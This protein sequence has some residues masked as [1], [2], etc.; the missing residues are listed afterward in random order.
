MSPTSTEPIETPT[1]KGE[2]LPCDAAT[3]ENTNFRLISNFVKFDSNPFYVPKESP[4]KLL[5]LRLVF[6]RLREQSKCSASEPGEEKLPFAAFQ[7]AFER[8]YFVLDDI[9][10]LDPELYDAKG[11]GCVAWEEFYYMFTKHHIRI[12]SSLVERIHLT[13]DNPE[14]S[15]VSQMISVVVLLTIILS[16]LC[17]I[18]STVPEFQDK[19]D[20]GSEPL[21]RPVFEKIDRI[22]VLLFVIEYFTRLATSWACRSEL[23][24][25]SQLLDIVTGYE[26]IRQPSSLE[27]LV[28]FIISPT[29]VIDFAAILPALLM[30][31]AFFSPFTGGE[32]DGGEN[33]FVILRLIRLTRVLRA[34]KNPAVAEPVI[35]M[36]RTMT[37]STQALYILGFQLLLGIV[38]FGSLIFIA[39]GQGEWDSES[40]TYL[41][42]VGIPVNGTQEKEST[43]FESIPLSFWWAIVTVA[44]VGYGDSFPRTSFGYIVAVAAMIFSLVILALPVG[45]VGTTFSDVWIAFDKEKKAEAAV[46]K[47]EKETIFGKIARLDPIRV[48]KRVLIEVWNDH[49]AFEESKV[50]PSG[51]LGEAKLELQLPPDRE[52]TEV[53]TMALGENYDMVKREVTG[54]VTFRYTWTP[55]ILMDDGGK[56]QG[57]GADEYALRGELLLT[58]IGTR[59]VLSLKAGTANIGSSPYCMV[60]LYPTAPEHTGAL[61][62]CIWRTPTAKDTVNAKWDASHSFQYSWPNLQDSNAEQLQ[63]WRKLEQKQSEHNAEF[64][65]SQLAIKRANGNDQEGSDGENELG[66]VLD[67]VRGLG[68]DLKQVKEE[69]CILGNRIRHFS[70]GQLPA[71]AS[72]AS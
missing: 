30:P 43:P 49:W 1:E 51:F 68:T 42:N 7:R 28:K 2:I 54:T 9:V 23:F 64:R 6:M 45:V 5:F 18:L 10:E 8:L 16:S 44:T 71:H 11:D 19:P 59:G 65:R 67:L 3:A 32:T 52:V 22:C 63:K 50:H 4:V 14:S 56:T 62:P 66:Q 60:Y 41:R 29:N 36:A 55:Y 17:F 35:V 20:D 25:D 24:K 47:R 12:K 57:L 34:F 40:R 13:L 15:R 48:S 61:K 39:E 37:Q 58:I 53:R 38:I 72:A 46:M 31:V 27:R 26:P 33:G 70:G 21:T 69:V